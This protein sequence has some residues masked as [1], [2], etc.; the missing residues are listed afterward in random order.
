MNQ[1]PSPLAP[2]VRFLLLVCALADP[3]S[4]QKIDVYLSLDGSSPMSGARWSTARELMKTLVND[5]VVGGANVVYGYQEWSSSRAPGCSPRVFVP[6]VNEVN[7][8]AAITS[9]LNM[10]VLPSGPTNVAG[11][12]EHLYNEYASNVIPNDTVPCRKRYV[13]VVTTGLS[14]CGDNPCA[15]AQALGLLGV[16]VIAVA[17]LGVPTG[18]LQCLANKTGGIVVWPNELPAMVHS[19]KT[20]L[21][22]EMARDSVDVTPSS[23]PSG[24]VNVPYSQTLSAAGGTPPYVFAV[25]AGVLPPGFSLGSQ[26]TLAGTSATPGSWPITIKAVGSSGCVGDRDYSLVVASRRRAPN[27]NLRNP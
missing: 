27:R 21:L 13:I 1:K 7:A 3:V 6:L 12:L 10:G 26:G 4:A 15:A 17:A 19:I 23:L 22:S 24:E 18:R 5:P 2:A 11:A 16:R 9:Q 8:T 14:A 20:Y 25:S